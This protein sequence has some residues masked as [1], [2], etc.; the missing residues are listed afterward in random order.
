VAEFTVPWTAVTE[1]RTVQE[2]DAL[3]AA[4][5]AY[6]TASA[7]A[8]LRHLRV[9]RVFSVQNGLLKHEQLASAFGAQQTIGAACRF[10]GEVLASG[11]VR[12]TLERE[13][14]L[15]PLPGQEV[16]PAQTLVHTLRLAG[17]QAGYAE[18][19]HALKWSKCVGWLACT[20]L[21]VLTRLKTYTFLSNPPT[22]RISTRVMREAGQLAAAPGPPG[23]SLPAALRLGCRGFR[24]PGGGRLARPRGKSA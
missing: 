22:A 1:P 10:A 6:D 13:C 11:A 2:V 9:Q 24:R 18:R 21:A 5:K 12:S 20:T 7:L 23:R 3:V 19:M 15:G 4:V 16:T 17:L 8:G 14:Y